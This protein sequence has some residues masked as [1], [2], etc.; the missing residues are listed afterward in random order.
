M[1]KWYVSDCQDLD[2]AWVTGAWPGSDTEGMPGEPHESGVT[3][4]AVKRRWGKGGGRREVSGPVLLGF[5]GKLGDQQLRNVSA[6]WYLTHGSL[7]Q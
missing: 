4:A 5:S 3:W 2:S 1:S 7:L 6:M